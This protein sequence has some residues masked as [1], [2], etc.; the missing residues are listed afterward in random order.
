M[1]GLSRGESDGLKW[2]VLFFT[3]V[4]WG[5]AFT[6]IKY[7]VGYFT[8]YELAFLR[9][10]T[11]NMLFIPTVL[12]RE[13]RIEREDIWKV[14]VLGI[15]GVAVYHVSLNAGETMV[16]SGVAS[17]I[18]ATAPV[19]VLIFS[20]FLLDESITFRKVAGI[21][22]SLLGVYVL[23]DPRSGGNPIGVLLVFLGTLSAGIY[24]VGGKIM[25]KKY[26]PQT[27]TAYAMILG[28]IP[29]LIYS[30]SSISKIV[31]ATPLLIFSVVFLG[32]FPTY[33][34]YQGWYYFLNKEEA[35]RAS[36]FLQTIPLVSIVAGNMLLNE[37]VTAY[38]IL[39]GFLIIG[40]V[41]LV[42]RN[43]GNG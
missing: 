23:T 30:E 25:M 28:T 9:F 43:N 1:Y 41:L 42:L 7:A 21:A 20:Y 26:S 24:T 36:V 35:S 4:F 37:P 22:L 39:G 19:F 5:L 3:V 33:I 38:T 32:I 14:F 18:I 34:S 17:L 13:Y 6:A 31:N 12:I 40:G 27:L 11:A 10:A 2:I 16:S 8:P 15:F 29:L